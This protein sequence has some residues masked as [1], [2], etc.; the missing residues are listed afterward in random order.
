MRY[1]PERSGTTNAKMALFFE[2][3]LGALEQLKSN[4]ASSLA[5]ESRLICLGA[6]TKVLTKLAFR[7]PDLDFNDAMDSLP[8]DADLSGIEE[9]IKPVTSRIRGI[10]RV[11][12]ERR[13]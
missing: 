13:D 1:A 4:W 2:V 12:G 7:Y 6:M 3:V 10:E 8:D 9:R 5:D 11:E